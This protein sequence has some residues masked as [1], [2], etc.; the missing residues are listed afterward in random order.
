MDKG[1]ACVSTACSCHSGK[2]YQE[3]CR[4]YHSGRLPKDA[5]SLMRSRYSAYALGLADYIMNTTH[6]KNPSI[7]LSPDRWKREILSFSRNT[8]FENLKIVEIIV[9]DDEVFVMFRASLRQ[10]LC[11]VSFTEKSR[12]EKVNGKWLYEDG[13]ISM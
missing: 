4:P 11:D 12:F 10:G 5:V 7:S 13:E 1:S 8:K 2:T 6:P 3:C 9:G